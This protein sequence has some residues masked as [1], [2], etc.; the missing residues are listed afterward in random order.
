MTLIRQIT[1]KTFSGKVLAIVKSTKEAGTITVTASADGLDSA[2]VKITTT[3][4]DNGSTEKQIDSFKMSRTYYVKVGSTP[5]LPEKIPNEDVNLSGTVE[6]E[7][8][9]GAVCE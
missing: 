8:L 6:E 9:S 4:V 7:Q 1:E 2:S 5:E 3:A